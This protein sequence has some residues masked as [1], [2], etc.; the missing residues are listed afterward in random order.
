MSDGSYRQQME[1]YGD[2]VD[3][4]DDDPEPY[5]KPIDP[6]L[7]VKLERGM[8]GSYGW[9]ITFTGPTRLHVFTQIELMDV[10]LRKKYG[11]PG[12]QQEALR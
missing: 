12:L 4:D 8:R 6:L 5:V 3:Q 1:A 11:T 2:A 7:T 9:T 10:M